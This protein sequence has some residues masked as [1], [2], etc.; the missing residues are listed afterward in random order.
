MCHAYVHMNNDSSS[1][2]VVIGIIAVS[3]LLF[4]GL[5]WLVASSSPSST[6]TE[7]NVAFEDANDPFIGKQD[8]AVTVHI[9]SDFQCPACKASEPIL[10]KIVE[11]YKDRVKFVWKDFPLETIHK[12]A[13]IGAVAARCAQAQGKYMEMHNKLFAEQTVWSNQS[14]PNESLKNYAKDLALDLGAFNT[15]LDNRAEDAKVAANISEANRNLVNATPTFFVN[16]KRYTGMYEQDWQNAI[17][18]ALGSNSAATS[19]Q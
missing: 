7:E 5:T 12:N 17:N 2:Q 16:N 4:G 1:K 10:K 15:C 3:V 11:Q 14:N 19:T 18:S 6:I 13:R 8:S 9:Y